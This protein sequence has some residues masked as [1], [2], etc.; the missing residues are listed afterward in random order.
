VVRFA[1][2]M[3]LTPGGHTRLASVGEP[4]KDELDELLGGGDEGNAN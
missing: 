3:G 2:E 4:P 1:T